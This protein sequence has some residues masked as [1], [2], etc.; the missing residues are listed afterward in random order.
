M[1]Y[2]QQLEENYVRS[3]YDSAGDR[4]SRNTFSEWERR[5][6]DAVLDDQ[7]EEDTNHEVVVHDKLTG[8]RL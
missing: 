5:G 1:E 6:V 7:F 8:Y 3:E 2:K 4:V